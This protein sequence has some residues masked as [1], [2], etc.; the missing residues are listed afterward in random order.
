[1]SNDNTVPAAMADQADLVLGKRT[2]AD[3]QP[4]GGVRLGNQAALK[5]LHAHLT[6]YPP[7]CNPEHVAVLGAALSA[8]PS[9]GGQG[10][11]LHDAVGRIFGCDG[12]PWRTRDVA[13]VLRDYAA[14]AA[15]QP[16]GEP[17][18]D[19][20]SAFQE[21]D[22]APYLVDAAGYYA[23][24]SFLTVAEEFRRSA[25]PH[26]EAINEGG[27]AGDDEISEVFDSHLN[28]AKRA[29]SRSTMYAAPPAQAVDLADF[30]ALYRAYVRLLESGRDRIRD[31]G[32]TCDPV[33]VMEA[34]DID[35]QAA[36]RV[37]DSQAVG[38]G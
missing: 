37:L 12:S 11:A 33:D 25:G 17:V 8:Q 10:E 4:G 1:M 2:L 27:S 20:D 19:Y 16:V 30:K 38:N 35:L 9:P 28:H 32:G 14:L 29:V 6:A 36:R 26:I 21:P 24:Q 22:H 23:L 3:A 15:R 7:P 5:R 34:N 13:A 31:L 18:D